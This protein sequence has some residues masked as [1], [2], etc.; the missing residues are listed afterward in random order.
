MR[1]PSAIYLASRCQPQS[2]HCLNVDA[3][4]F[5]S[6]CAVKQKSAR[7]VLITRSLYDECNVNSGV[8]KQVFGYQITLAGCDLFHLKSSASSWSGLSHWHAVNAQIYKTLR[9]SKDNLTHFI[10]R[11]ERAHP[12]VV[13][14]ILTQKPF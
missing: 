14:P 7:L 12:K 13:E 9:I 8:A 10:Y 5:K 1:Q 6:R 2:R 4:K 3:L 11:S